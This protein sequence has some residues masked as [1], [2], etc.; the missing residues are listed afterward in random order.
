MAE[1]LDRRPRLVFK[2]RNNTGGGSHGRLAAGRS[3]RWVN[4]RSL[5]RCLTTDYA[6]TIGPLQGRDTLR[7]DQVGHGE[8]R[9]RARHL[10]QHAIVVHLQDANRIRRD[11]LRGG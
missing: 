2:Q 5:G 9:R 1:T 4:R 6:M 3:R 7:T 10:G 8:E 11:V